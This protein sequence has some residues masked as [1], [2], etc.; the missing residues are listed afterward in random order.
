MK[1]IGKLIFFP[2][3]MVTSNTNSLNILNSASMFIV[4][5]LLL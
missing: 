4:Y 2:N 5:K 3:K 1:L